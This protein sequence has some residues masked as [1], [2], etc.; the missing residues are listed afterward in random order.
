VAWSD[1]VDDIVAGDLTAAVAYAT[2]AG[3]AVVT[4]VAP[5]GLRDREAGTVTF[6]TSLGFGRKLERI[7]RN[8]RVALAYHAREH[9]FATAPDFVLVQGLAEASV[10]PDR[11]VLEDIVQPSAE[12]FM[13]P[14]KR[15]KLFWDRWLQEYYQDRVLVTVQVERVTVWPDQRCAGEPALSGSPPAPPPAPQD[16]PAKGTAPRVPTERAGRRLGALPH[17]LLAF[18]S[19]DGY[20]DVVPFDVVSADSGGISISTERRLPAGGRRAGL[21][22]HSFRPQLIGLVSRQHTGWLAVDDSGA[23][24]YAPH[25]ESGFRAPANKTLLLLANGLLAKRGLKRARAAAAR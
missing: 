21:I 23:A 4:A 8:P 24:T 9:G 25:T 15:G 7:Q 11:R 1:D 18:V 10:E 6:T 14:P 17:R 16:E 13:G 19:G 20:P 2:P 22:A 12:R 3:G 5:V